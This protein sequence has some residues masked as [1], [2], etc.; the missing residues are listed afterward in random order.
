MTIDLLE[1]NLL[2][3]GLLPSTL[4]NKL[5]HLHVDWREV[6]QLTPLKVSRYLSETPPIRQIFTR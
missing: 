5:F 3:G 1:V 4:E 6:Y 2:S